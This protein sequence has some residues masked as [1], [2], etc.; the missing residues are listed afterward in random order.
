[1]AALLADARAAGLEC[2][3][4]RVAA[5]RRQGSDGWRLV[6]DGGDALA[7]TPWLVLTA[8]LASTA[9]LQDLGHPMP[10]RPVLG[11]AVRLRLAAPP[12]WTWPG[13]VVWRGFNLVPRPDRPGGRDLWLG[14]TLEP[15]E[16]ADPGQLAELLG[17]SG[18]ELDW[19]ATARLQQSWQGLR[20]RPSGRPA[21]VLEQLEPGL[22]VA[23]GHYRNGV[24]LA[25]ASAAWVVEQVEASGQPR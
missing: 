12:A 10:M 4:Q 9:L 3:P 16:A 21:P 1:M 6:G 15:G 5:I 18:A 13:V 7:A 22:L 19:L 11:Q 8:G 24:L 20:A 25:P 17:W 23:G 2:L 14:A